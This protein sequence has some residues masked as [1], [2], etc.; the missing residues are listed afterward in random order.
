M[1][2]QIICVPAGIVNVDDTNK[3]SVV[4]IQSKDQTVVPSPG[5]VV[6]AMVTTINQDMCKCLITTVCG[7]ELNETYRSSLRRQDVRTKEID[8]IDMLL[9]FRPGDIILAKIL[10]MTEAHTFKLTT[11]EN[12]LGVVIA[13][14][15]YGY[16]MVPISWTEMQCTK[17][18]TIEYRKVAKIVKDEQ[19]IKTT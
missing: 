18:N 2:N 12:E 14:S 6:T 16:S 1:E 11:A 3:I 7:H 13:C 10:P 15:E 19:E 4:N 17:T 5:D 8:K 9:C